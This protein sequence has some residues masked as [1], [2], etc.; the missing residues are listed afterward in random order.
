MY[1]CLLYKNICLLKD[2]VPFER[3]KV[4]KK[5]AQITL[6]DNNPEPGEHWYSLAAE[7]RSVFEAGNG[8]KKGNNG[9]S[10]IAQTSPFFVKVQ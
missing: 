3:E 10:V 6:C 8:L 1:L 2:G 9:E 5:Q 4:G 7:G